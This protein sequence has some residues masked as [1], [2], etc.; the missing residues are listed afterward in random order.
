MSKSIENDLCS[1]ENS[2]IDDVAHKYDDARWNHKWTESPSENENYVVFKLI[3]A[4]SNLSN[5]CQN[6]SYFYAKWL[7][8]IKLSKIIILRK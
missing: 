1:P 4:E 6:R 7:E 2:D 3:K 5:I 8:N